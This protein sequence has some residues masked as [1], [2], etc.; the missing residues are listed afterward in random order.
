MIILVGIMSPWIDRGDGGVVVLEAKPIV[1]H[2]VPHVVSRVYRP[3]RRHKVGRDVVDFT[4]VEGDICEHLRNG[5]FHVGRRVFD[6]IFYLE[7]VGVG[8]NDEI[9]GIR[10]LVL[11]CRERKI[12]K[13]HLNVVV[14]KGGETP[15]E[16]QTKRKF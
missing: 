10:R 16:L 8:G 3:S 11:G 13:R 14:S 5:H 2:S 7:V 9:G 15:K 6:G 4:L 12:G 1:V